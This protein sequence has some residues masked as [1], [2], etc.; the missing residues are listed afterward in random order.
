MSMLPEKPVDAPPARSGISTLSKFLIGCGV[1]GLLG[2]LACAGVGVWAFRWGMQQVDA[3][4]KE[5]VDSGYERQMGQAIEVVQSPEKKTVYVCQVLN[6]RKEVDVDIAVVSQ[7]CEVHADIHGDVDF[8]GQVLK[9]DSGVVIHGDLRVKNA[10]VVE[11]HG[12]V[13]GT[14]SGNYMVLNQE[15]SFGPGQSPNP[16]APK[17]APTAIPDDVPTAEATLPKESTNESG[18]PP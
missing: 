3:V 14:I 4:A 6:V 9:V 12:E 8:F 11:I 2:I 5:F 18:S 1:I 7:V 15:K 10:Q 13:K 16:P 17:D